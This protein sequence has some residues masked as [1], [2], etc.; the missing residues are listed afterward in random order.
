MRS[1]R[2]LTR[3]LTACAI[4]LAS[5]VVFAQSP[6]IIGYYPS[7]KASSDTSGMTPANIPY[8]GLTIINY[9]FF[10]PLP[11]GSI[12]GRN[13]SG[14][15]VVLA[16]RMSPG[17]PRDLHASLAE[18]AHRHGVR[19]MLSIGGWED[20]DT[21][22][23]VASEASSRITFAHACSDFIRTW[24]FDGIDID[25]EF[26]GYSE[27][28]GTPADK[29]NFSLLLRTLRD[30]LDALGTAAGTKLLL[31]AALP[32]GVEH[33]SR[34][35]VP[36]IAG[37]LD[38]LNIMTYDFYGSWDSVA[39]HNA[40]LYAGIGGD[41]ARSVHGAFLLYT[42]TYKVS[43]A[44]ITL[45]VPFYG[46]TYSRCSALNTPHGGAD[47]VHFPH[48]GAW[49][50]AINSMKGHFTR[51]WDERAKV[52]YLVS[53]EWNLLVS[54]DDEESVRWKAAYAAEHGVRGLIIWEITA[55]LLPD[56]S[57]PLLDAVRTTL[58]PPSGERT[59]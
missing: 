11:D 23:A 19:V 10:Y 6:E 27:H 14:D 15:S 22:P 13:A 28:K 16:G 5:Q 12:V 50:S 42:Q 40:P 30:S 25:W 21:F 32:A 54:Y 24:G 4:M 9:A 37:I 41:P 48:Q 45:G 1:S 18:T 43:P 58:P 39:N 55:D 31:T 53:T 7:W 3:P 46:H 57:H 34:I 49:Y 56:G 26:P 47:S 51:Q 36:V 59:R 2:T 33:A 38:F 8:N 44:H 20:S 29:V 17:S 35:D 52:P